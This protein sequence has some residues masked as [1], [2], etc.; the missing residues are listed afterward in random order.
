MLDLQLN[1]NTLGAGGHCEYIRFRNDN[2][3]GLC[4]PISNHIGEDGTP[5]A[6]S[7][8][9]HLVG[10]VIKDIYCKSGYARAGTYDPS[11][12]GPKC[13][14]EPINQKKTGVRGKGQN[15]DNTSISKQ[16]AAVI[17]HW[18]QECIAQNMLVQ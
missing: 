1:A 3:P 13:V 5:V 18:F 14:N 4:L 11:R 2:V 7:H 12:K 16:E 9:M 17:Y 10:G 6:F 8:R 15:S